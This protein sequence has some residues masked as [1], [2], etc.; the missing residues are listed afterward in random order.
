M[1]E[2]ES[3]ASE[4]QTQLTAAQQDLLT[5]QQDHRDAKQTIEDLQARL[6]GKEEKTLQLQTQLAKAQKQMSVDTQAHED[7]AAQ[8]QAEMEA[9]QQGHED[10]IA[11]CQR[12]SR[13]AQQMGALLQT[14]WKEG[15]QEVASERQA[16]QAAKQT[17]AEVQLELGKEASR[18][19]SLHQVSTG[20]GP[21][22]LYGAALY[23]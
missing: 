14:K 1:V 20:Q 11:K 9:A 7:A 3:N 4:L 13:A 15:Q 2:A 10:A 23:A 12:Q 22:M 17:V 19:K 8:S 16:H 6:Q 21:L 5:E 18:A